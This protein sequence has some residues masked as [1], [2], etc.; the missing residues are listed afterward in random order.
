MASKNFV[1]DFYLSSIY[2]YLHFQY[3]GW[4]FFACMGLAFGF[5]NLR[6]SDHS[7]YETSF[8]LFAIACVPAYFLSTLWLE[9]PLWLYVITVI[10]AMTQVFSWFK[11][12]ICKSLATRATNWTFA[13]PGIEGCSNLDT[14]RRRHDFGVSWIA[15]RSILS[16]MAA[17]IGGR[18]PCGRS[19]CLLAKPTADR[20][21]KHAMAD[22]HCKRFLDRDA[23]QLVQYVGQHGCTERRSGGDY[24]IDVGADADDC[25]HVI[26]SLRC[27]IAT[28]VVCRGHAFGFGGF[29]VGF[30]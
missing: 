19:S 15:R 1:Q 9:L 10:A 17:S 23:H 20:L 21:H 3:N 16:P 25:S 30:S 4:F 18:V 2:Y 22:F 12:L 28:S 13:R 14:H 24:W 26:A 6:K 5:L 7:F 29:S 11:F 8:K 27:P